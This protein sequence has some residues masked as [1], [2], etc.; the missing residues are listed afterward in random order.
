MAP[1]GWAGPPNGRTTAALAVV[2]LAAGATAAAALALRA[3][4][5]QQRR[6]RRCGL[7]VEDCLSEGS[8]T[9]R[10]LPDPPSAGPAEAPPPTAQ[11]E[12]DALLD[13]GLRALGMMSGPVAD[14]EDRQLPMQAPA[15]QRHSHHPYIEGGDDEADET[16]VVERVSPEEERRRYFANLGGDDL[17]AGIDAPAG[18][19]DY[20]PAEEKRSVRRP[21]VAYE[22]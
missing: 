13:E 16:V 11:S 21:V 5:A 18:E 7:A 14:R 22:D 9:P 4:S 19:V 17:F 10:A 20:L 3:G 2:A 8:D 6:R 1:A 15:S 12:H